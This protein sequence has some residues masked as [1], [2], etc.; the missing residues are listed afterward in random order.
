MNTESLYRPTGESELALVKASGSRRWPSRLPEQPIFYPV[1][2]ERYATEIAQR[3]NAR[4]GNLGIV[5]RFEVES[6]YLAR[7]E[8]KCVGAS[9]H[10]EYWIPAEELDAFNDRIVGEIEVVA[11]YKDGEKIEDS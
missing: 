4:D 2:N 9:H 11:T 5:T 6:D 3:W 8:V 7:F 1:T 10:T